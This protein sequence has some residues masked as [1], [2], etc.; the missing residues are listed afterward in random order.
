MKRFNK[1]QKKSEGLYRITMP[2]YITTI[3]SPMGKTG[4]LACYPNEIVL[5]WHLKNGSVIIGQSG[6]M[7]TNA[8]VRR[9]DQLF[10]IA[11]NSD[12]KH[13]FVLESVYTIPPMCTIEN[14]V[15]SFYHDVM[16]KESNCSKFF[17]DLDGLVD[18]DKIDMPKELD[19]FGYKKLLSEDPALTITKIDNGNGYMQ[20]VSDEIAVPLDDLFPNHCN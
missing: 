3:T 18:R 5:Q 17:V 16:Q 14:A 2:V 15:K 20:T 13:A 8:F 6:P 1:K 7:L 12:P 11:L 19:I 9:K 4:R 10:S